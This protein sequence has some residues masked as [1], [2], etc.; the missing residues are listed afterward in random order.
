MLYTETVEPGTF[1]L[2]KELMN[3]PELKAFSLVGGTA[4]ALRYGHRSSVDLDLFFHEKFDHPTIIS[5]L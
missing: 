3:L 5:S 2:L 4:L 1:S